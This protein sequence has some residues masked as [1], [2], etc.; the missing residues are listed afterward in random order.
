MPRARDCYVIYD[1]QTYRYLQVVASGVN[2][3]GKGPTTVH[4]ARQSVHPAARVEDPA[5]LNTAVT[6]EHC[7]LDAILAGTGALQHR[8]VVWFIFG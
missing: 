7:I 4:A 1:L 8:S 2:S 3:M 6:G 5:D